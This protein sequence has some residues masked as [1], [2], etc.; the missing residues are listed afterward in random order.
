M[1]TPATTDPRS[2]LAPGPNQGACRCLSTDAAGWLD[3]RCVW[4]EVLTA[5]QAFAYGSPSD[6]QLIGFAPVLAAMVHDAAYRAR[7]DALRRRLASWPGTRKSFAS[8]YRLSRSRLYS[9]I[10]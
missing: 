3:C 2:F 10:D 1:H 8:A 6:D 9:I 5:V 7:D 4:N